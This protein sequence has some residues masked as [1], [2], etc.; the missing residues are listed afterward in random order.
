M[1]KDEL[2]QCCQDAAHGSLIVWLALRQIPA[3]PQSRYDARLSHRDLSVVDPTC[4]V[5]PERRIGPS[6]ALVR[7]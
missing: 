7:R 2:Q 6:F 3:G 1:N 4:V 5:G